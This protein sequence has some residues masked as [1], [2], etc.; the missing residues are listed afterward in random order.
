LNH[1]LEIFDQYGLSVHSL[2]ANYIAR[3]ISKFILKNDLL[4]NSLN[5][6][7]KRTLSL[8]NSPF[9]EE[10]NTLINYDNM[11]ISESEFNK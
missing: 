11:K 8:I 4:Y 9:A 6:K 10:I 2:P 7:L 5:L 3:Y 1:L